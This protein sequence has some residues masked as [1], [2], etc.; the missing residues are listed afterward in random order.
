VVGEDVKEDIKEDVKQDIKENV[1]EQF[2]EDTKE[3]FKE[4]VMDLHRYKI[5]I[6]VLTAKTNRII[7]K[8]IKAEDLN[9]T[10]GREILSASKMMTYLS[11]PSL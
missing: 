4:D 7:T 5:T 6:I 11:E 2:K 3:E 9:V 10:K 8:T 1:K